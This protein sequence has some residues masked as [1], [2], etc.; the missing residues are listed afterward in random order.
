MRNILTGWELDSSFFRYLTGSPKH[1]H[2][3]LNI[4]SATDDDPSQ[5]IQATASVSGIPILALMG[6]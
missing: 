2:I 3:P 5:S 6:K 4:A 1:E